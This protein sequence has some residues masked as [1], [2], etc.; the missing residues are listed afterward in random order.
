[1]V[2]YKQK[3]LI[4]VIALF[5]ILLLSGHSAYALLITH[6]EAHVYNIQITPASGGID[7]LFDPW[8]V[9]AFASAFDEP[10]GFD[11][12]YDDD[13]DMDGEAAASAATAFVSESSAASSNNMTIDVV[14]DVNVTSGEFFL[15]AT[16]FGEL[17]NVF[18]ITEM[19]PM[20]VTFSLDYSAQLLGQADELGWFDIEYGINM[21]ISDGTTDYTLDTFNALTSDGTITDM[22]TLSDTFILQPFTFYSIDIAVDPN[23]DG[24]HVPEPATTLLF[25]IGIAGIA[26]LRRRNRSRI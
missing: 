25:G 21:V 18:M 5:G 20:D 9:V 13:P 6:S 24:T 22:G 7:F 26:I 17:Y 23:T 2:A 12:D 3:V 16:G 1:M 8:L 14:S 4:S 15:N 11:Q 19:I 10:S